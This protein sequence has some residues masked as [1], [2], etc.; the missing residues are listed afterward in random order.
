MQSSL[1]GPDEVE[2]SPRDMALLEAHLR[3][4]V[5]FA[6]IQQEKKV[7]GHSPTEA[8]RNKLTLIRDFNRRLTGN[9]SAEETPKPTEPAAEQIAPSTPSDDS[10]LALLR[11]FT[12]GVVD[13]RI[14]K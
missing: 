3:Q 11:L 5:S 9:Q 1:A 7:T 14:G 8:A 2:L 6:T 10:S 12:N 13:D 4:P